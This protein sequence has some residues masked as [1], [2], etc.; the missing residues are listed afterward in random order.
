MNTRSR[1]RRAAVAAIAGLTALAV[2]PA[3]ASSHREAP[4]ITEDPC[5]DITDVYG[6]TSPDRANTTT[7]IMNVIP[8]EL[9]AGGPNFHKPCDDVLYE[10]KVDNDGNA[11]EDISYQFRFTTKVTNPNTFLYNTGQVTSLDD[12][13]LNIRQTYTVTEM[14]GNRRAVIGR[15][16]AVA[17]AN[18]GTRSMPDYNALANGAI[19][20]LQDGI[21][22]FVGPRDDPFFADL[23]AIFDLGG[24]RPLNQAHL[25]KL[26]TEAG[27]DYLAGFNVHTIALQ[28]PNSE[29]TAGGDPVIG[30]WATTSRRGENSKGI[31]E[32]WKQVARLGM[33]LVNE[34]VVPVGAKD[35]FN[36]SHPSK[37]GQFAAGVLDPELGKLIPVLY[38]GVKVPTQV[39]TG[40]KLGGRED[41]A[42]IFLTGIPG[43]NQPKKVTPSEM[44]RI[45]TS[46]KSGFPNG[47]TLT[48]DVVDA[49]LQVV[50]GATDFSPAFKIAPNNA[51][52]DGVGANDKPFLGSFPYVPA[53]NSGYTSSLYGGK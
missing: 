2:T 12:A 33:P 7:L 50:A 52:G 18:V 29:L 20:D 28:I 32:N 1:K 15:D 5:A 34:V 22:S 36:T 27:R 39:S 51:L 13:D 16:I 38:P 3:M 10:L 6:F 48:D 35:L 8:F 43:V 47:R 45:N 17:P 49:S 44:L 42:T 37:D 30:V 41:I 25:V 21:K 53:P 31:G 14:K 40:L 4:A 46:T 24:L 11:V 23:G 19:A 9:P 26:P